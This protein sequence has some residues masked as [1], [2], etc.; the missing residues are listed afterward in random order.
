MRCWLHCFCH[1]K[2]QHSI[3]PQHG[4]DP[5]IALTQFS[6]MWLC[7]YDRHRH[8]CSWTMDIHNHTTG[9]C[10]LKWQSG[11]DNN[12]DHKTTNLVRFSTMQAC[13]FRV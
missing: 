5:N 12:V 6:K 2:P 11:W 13:R 4:V 3:S 1:I 8:P 7:T 10:W 9:D